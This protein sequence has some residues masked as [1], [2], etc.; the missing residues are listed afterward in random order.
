MTERSES[1]DCGT[2]CAGLFL[3]A[4]VIGTIV[5]AAISI[6]AGEQLPQ[7]DAAAGPGVH[8]G[9]APGTLGERPRMTASSGQ[10]SVAASLA[11]IQPSAD[12]HAVVA[13]PRHSHTQLVVPRLRIKVL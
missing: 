5:A 6:T 9:S 11:V 13:R 1:D 4:L 7:F 8:A 12:D 3:A 2:G 10:R